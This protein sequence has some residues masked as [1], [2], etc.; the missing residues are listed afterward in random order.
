MPS[1]LRSPISLLALPEVPPCCVDPLGAFQSS[2]PPWVVD[3]S[4]P[5]QPSKPWTPPQPIDPSAPP[6]LDAPLASPQTAFPA[7]PSGSILVHC[8]SGF[9]SDFRVSS[10]STPGLRHHPVSSSPFLTPHPLS[11]PQSVVSL[12]LPRPC[13]QAPPWLIPPLAP[14]WTFNLSWLWSSSCLSCL[15]LAPPTFTSTLVSLVIVS[16]VSSPACSRAPAF[17]P[18]SIWTVL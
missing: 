14:P 11:P 4:A 5:P 13:T 12:I 9:A 10:C 8:H 1:S 6:W 18:F 16:L 2:A 17:S 15:P 3:P 7:H